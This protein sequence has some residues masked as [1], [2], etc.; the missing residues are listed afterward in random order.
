MRLYLKNTQ[1]KNRAGRVAQAVE[2]LPSKCQ[3]SVLPKNKNKKK[4]D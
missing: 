1:N 4:K 2:R 3:T